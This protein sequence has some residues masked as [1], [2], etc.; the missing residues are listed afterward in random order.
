MD[1]YLRFY[2]L[3]ELASG[4]VAINGIGEAQPPTPALPLPGGGGSSVQQTAQ[5]LS[6]KLPLMGA[7]GSNAVAVGSAGTRDHKHGLLLGNPHFPWSG[8]ERFYQA[9]MTIPGTLD[10]EGVSL[11]GVPVMLIGHTKSMAWSHTVS[12]AYRFTPYQLTL[13]PGSPT[14]YLYDGKPEQMTSR[15][16]TIAV[17]QPDGSLKPQSR[18]LWSSR[19]GPIFDSLVGVPLPWTPGTAFAMAD[20]NADNFRV[21]QPLPGDLAGA[22]RPAGAGDPQE[23]RGHPVGEHDRG[24][25]RWARPLRRHRLDPERVRRARPRPATP[26]SARPP[27][28]CSGCRCWTGRARPARGT[29][30]RT[31]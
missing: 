4:D 6:H 9:Q 10:V 13:V 20:A 19:F 26:C 24:R 8:P 17:R 1:A 29:R 22:I 12:T 14:T 3:V 7:I 23:V 5:E 2:Q 18:T 15:V 30:T 25:P 16:V 11:F 31:R 27:S 28:S 21:L